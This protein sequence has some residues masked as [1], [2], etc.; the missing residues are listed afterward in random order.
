MK[1][2]YITKLTV[3][4]FLG[5]ELLKI[6]EVGKTTRFTGDQGTGKTSALT[7]VEALFRSTG[8]DVSFIRNGADKAKIIVEMNGGEITC[9]RT[10]TQ[11][12]NTPRVTVNGEPVSKA[13]TFLDELYKL[14]YIFRPLDFLDG[15]K[16]SRRSLLLQAIP[17]RIEREWM[18]EKLADIAAEIDFDRFDF[19]KHGL[20]LI[21]EIQRHVYDR[22]TEVNRDRDQL[23]KAILQD[24][25]DLPES[26]DLAR[27][28]SYNAA[29]RRE[30]LANA[31]K[32]IAGHQ[33]DIRLRDSMRQQNTA[34]DN[35][36][37]AID[38]QIL[39][40]QQRKI[41][42][43]A[44]QEKL[45]KDGQA[46]SA[47]IEEFQKPDVTAI[48]VELAEYDKFRDLKSSIELV[49][50]REKQLEAKDT[51]WAALDETYKMLVDDIPREILAGM[52]MPVPGV[53]LRGDDIYVDGIPLDKRS[54]TEQLTFILSLARELAD[55][56]EA[57]LRVLM[58]DNFESCGSDLCEELA[59][60]QEE[61]GW[62][63]LIAEVCRGKK[64][65]EYEKVG[66]V[67]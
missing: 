37:T 34:I 52:K 38:D 58:L 33:S 47:K 8:R 36:I 45:V 63:Y 23:A 24:K 29:A 20:D 10:I 27:F 62:Q 25:K 18:A 12:T 32:L 17:V 26:L 66:K 14:P 48:R 64:R 21:G 44:K 50:A 43:E 7:A 22:R 65:L 4:D 31:E 60:A 54:R 19:S 41:E 1:P 40:L 6:D 30:D 67:F 5:I 51:T 11:K 56:M 57:P 28:S 15:D 16:R 2:L 53:E 13:Q 35:E 59:R 3:E 61:D 55:R 42:L 9:E 39:K 49:R 46:L